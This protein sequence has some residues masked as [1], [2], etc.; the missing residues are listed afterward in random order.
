[1]IEIFFT[2]KTVKKSP[3]KKGNSVK[4]PPLEECFFKSPIEG[5]LLNFFERFLKKSPHWKEFEKPPLK[6]FFLKTQIGCFRTLKKFFKNPQH[7]IHPTRAFQILSVFRSAIFEWNQ[8]KQIFTEIRL[9]K[10]PNH[11]KNQRLILILLYF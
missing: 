4:I 11:P 10:I 3:P 7:L 9:K 5:N 6:R 2:R 8:S 1:M